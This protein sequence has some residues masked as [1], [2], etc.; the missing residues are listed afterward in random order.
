MK[1]YLLLLIAVF[2][3]WACN[4]RPAKVEEEQQPEEELVVETPDLA[5]QYL[6][7][8]AVTPEGAELSLHE[9]V[10]KTDYVL[11]DF[12]ASWCGP[13][14]RLIPVLKEIYAGQ[15]REHFQIFSCSV[16]QDEAMW[17][18]ALEEEQMPWPQAREDENHVC[19]DLYGVQYIPFT[20]LIDKEGHIVAINP[21]E[22]DLEI[23]LFNE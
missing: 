19:S 8:T 5:E 15:A 4:T 13:C 11:V 9:L 21:E 7:F 14:R 6:D 22:A 2:A 3:F 23:I 10:G 16:D 12:W 1:K 20:V 18:K 17:R